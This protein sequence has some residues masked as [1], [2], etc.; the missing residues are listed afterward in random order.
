MWYLGYGVTATILSP[1]TITSFIVVVMGFI[2]Y[3]II[4]EHCRNFVAW[5][6]F[7]NKYHLRIIPLQFSFLKNQ[8]VSK[9]SLN[10]PNMEPT[11]NGRFKEVM[12]L[13]SY[14][15]CRT[16]RYL[17]RKESDRHRGVVDVWRWSAREVLL[18]VILWFYGSGPYKCCILLV[19]A[20][21]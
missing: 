4:P 6:N 16:V 19:S 13:G 3:L 7:S 8:V 9:A 11:L 2:F 5:G 20:V 21:Y 18:Y 17:G 10:R 12:D 15:I 1:V 14:D